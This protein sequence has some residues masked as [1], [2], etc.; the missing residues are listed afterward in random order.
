MLQT[1]RKSKSKGTLLLLVPVTQVVPS[2]ITLLLWGVLYPTLFCACS[3]DSKAQALVFCL[4]LR[5]RAGKKTARV[6]TS[7]QCAEFIKYWSYQTPPG[8]YE[9][10]RYSVSLQKENFAG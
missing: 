7:G 3:L 10:Y 4:A 6:A 2:L 9:N 5:I 8:V 1:H